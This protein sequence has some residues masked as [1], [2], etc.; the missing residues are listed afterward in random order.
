[1]LFHV[2]IIP[3]QGD[4]RGSADLG[5]FAMELIGTITPDRPL[6]VA[7]LKLEAVHLGRSGLPVLVTGA[8]KVNAA[9]VTARVLADSKPSEVIN[10]G[11]AGAL[12]D[13]LEGIHEIA[14]VEQHDFDEKSL[15]ELAGIEFCPPVV[16]AEQG[17]RLATGDV[18]VSDSEARARLAQ[19]ADLVD[20]EGYSIAFACRSVDVPVRLVKHVSDSANE[21]AFKSWEASVGASAEVLADWVDANL[22]I[23]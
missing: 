9:V 22:A 12:R 18:F 19:R 14:R 20:M 7:A 2:A 17:I 6:L 5:F 4:I 23:A 16:I 8:G 1:V 10:L 3:H 13:G 15:F 21:H 11:T